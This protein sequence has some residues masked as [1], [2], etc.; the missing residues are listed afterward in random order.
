M[1]V[2]PATRYVATPSSERSLDADRDAADREERIALARLEAEHAADTAARINARGLEPATPEEGAYLHL[3][4]AMRE[5]MKKVSEWTL[6]E[7]AHI[8]FGKFCAYDRNAKFKQLSEKLARDSHMTFMCYFDIAAKTKNLPQ[9]KARMNFVGCPIESTIR[10]R[11]IPECGRIMALKYM[12][13]KDEVPDAGIKSGSN[14][15]TSD[16]ETFMET[17]EGDHD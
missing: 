14:W 10:V 16:L 15:I 12:C 4:V 7:A 13:E 1:E 8:D 3:P 11:T 2:V 17:A 5:P 9:W 6:N